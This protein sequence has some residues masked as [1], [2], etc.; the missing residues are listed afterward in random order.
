MAAITVLLLLAVAVV[1]YFKCRLNMKLWHKNS[2]GDYELSD[3]K[4]CD[5]YISYV[6]NDHDRKFVNFILKPHLESKNAYKV[7]LNDNDILPGSGK[8]YQQYYR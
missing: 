5:V 3:G 4:L 6:N 8:P 1:V 7:H 2:Y